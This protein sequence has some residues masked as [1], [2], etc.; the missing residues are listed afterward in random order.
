MKDF[1]KWKNMLLKKMI[2]LYD[3]FYVDYYDDLSR[4]INKLKF[5]FNEI[6]HTTK[7][8]KKN[9]NILDVGCG[10]G[11]L[12]QKFVKKVIKLKV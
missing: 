9:S 3:E 7:P 10:T 11:N 4:D 12:V 1:H 5:E 2:D 6:C 8:D